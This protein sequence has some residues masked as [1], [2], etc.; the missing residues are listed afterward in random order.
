M[1]ALHQPND[2]AKR[3]YILKR[4]NHSVWF[5]YGQLH[6]NTIDGLWSHAKKLT[7]KF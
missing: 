6:I 2:F 1:F 7:K 5:W 3:D 4:V